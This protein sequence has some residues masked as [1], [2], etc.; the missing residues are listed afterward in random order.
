M[1]LGIAAFIGSAF[2]FG[3][4]LGLSLKGSGFLLELSK[5]GIV[6]LVGITLGGGTGFLCSLLLRGAP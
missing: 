6:A 2:G 1:L 3:V 5:A 4:L